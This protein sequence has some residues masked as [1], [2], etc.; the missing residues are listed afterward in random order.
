M[1]TSLH[2]TLKRRQSFSG[3]TRKSIHRTVAL[4]TGPYLAAIKATK[5]AHSVGFVRYLTLEWK[6]LPSNINFKHPSH[7]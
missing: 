4:E 3:E 6:T 5:K 7:A 2:I 1:G